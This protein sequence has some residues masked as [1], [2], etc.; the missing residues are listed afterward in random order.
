MKK[1]RNSK[2]KDCGNV[3]DTTGIMIAYKKPYQ[4]DLC[5]AKYW[6]M[7]TNVIKVKL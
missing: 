5:H 7:I 6:D 2:C 1:T 4:C 3:D